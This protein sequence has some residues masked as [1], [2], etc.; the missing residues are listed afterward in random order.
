M[1]QSTATS[2]KSASKFRLPLRYSLRMLLL[3]LTAFA[4]GFPVWY[5]LPYEESTDPLAS[6]AGRAPKVSNK[7]VTT[8]QQQWGGG[9][10]MHGPQVRYVNGKMFSKETYSNGE[11][12]GP[13]TYW[14]PDGTK[15][16]VEIV[17]GKKDGVWTHV[18]ASGKTRRTAT[19]RADR[20][21]GPC[22]A[23]HHDGSRSELVFV[24]GRLATYDG[25]AISDPLLKHLAD[26]TV[27][28][29]LAREL[30]RDTRIEFMETQLKDA[31]EFLMAQH[32]I[33]FIL[34][35]HHGLRDTPISGQ[36]DHIQLASAL[37]I[38]TS[39]NGHACDYRYG[40]VWVT[41]ARDAINWH[42]PT[43]VAEIQPPKGSQ[44][45]KS[46]DER[47][48][49]E[50]IEQPLATVV[51]TLVQTLA[52]GLDTWGIESA[53]GNYPVTL[54]VDGFPFRDTLG[55]LLYETRCRVKLDGETLVILPPE[56]ER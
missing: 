50:V 14:I 31:L 4:I 51:Q 52:I 11:L 56:E 19:W 34:D 3:A 16:F 7:L 6:A 37:A 21:H 41:S 5:R 36:F 46:W 13:C 25:K 22:I 20:L 42:D 47:V 32:S 35:P 18:D 15:E 29:R 8:W 28:A 33:P 30:G 54:T 40:L 27:E 9:R 55:L 26:G 45:A 44:L 12:H 10:L 38:I 1:N 39:E 23:F 17:H 2:A 48:K 43:G 49:I 53:K 24:D